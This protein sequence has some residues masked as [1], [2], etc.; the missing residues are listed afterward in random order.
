M[1]NVRGSSLLWASSYPTFFFISQTKCLRS[2]KKRPI[3]QLPESWG[4]RLDWFLCICYQT[5]F[6]KLRTTTKEKS[7]CNKYHYSLLRLLCSEW[8]S[9]LSKESGVPRSIE[10]EAIHSSC[11]VRGLIY[12]LATP[13]LA[14]PFLSRIITYSSDKYSSGSEWTGWLVWEIRESQ[15]S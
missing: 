14:T 2:L 11:R 6:L 4:L 1:I 13:F 8:V 9:V 3:N 7:N 10:E 5:L 15:V 12:A